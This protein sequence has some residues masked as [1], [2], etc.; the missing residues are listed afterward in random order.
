MILKDA[1]RRSIVFYTADNIPCTKPQWPSTCGVIK[2]THCQRCHS[3]HDVGYKRSKLLYETGKIPLHRSAVVVAFYDLQ[4][5]YTTHLIEKQGSVHHKSCEFFVFVS[6][7]L[8]KP[9]RVAGLR[10]CSL[11]RSTSCAYARNSYHIQL[12]SSRS[13]KGGQFDGL[14]SI[15]SSLPT[16]KGTMTFLAARK[17]CPIFN[18]RRGNLDEWSLEPELEDVVD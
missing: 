3:T 7:H 6:L 14:C 11:H 15:I 17:A 2:T 18:L 13:A 12:Y 10:K 16:L 1:P 4:L 9:P 5:G 8:D